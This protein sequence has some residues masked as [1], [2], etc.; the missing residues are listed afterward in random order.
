VERSRQ[1][2]TQDDPQSSRPAESALYALEEVTDHLRREV[3]LTL[4]GHGMTTSQY[5]VLRALRIHGT[6]GLTC[7]ELGDRLSGA[8]PDIT[9]LL[10]RLSRQQLI[11]RRRDPHDRRAVVTELT[12]E[13]AR[14]LAVV[15]P[16]LEARIAA[17]FQHMSAERL[18]LLLEL[19]EEVAEGD[20]RKPMQVHAMRAG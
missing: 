19:L 3:H 6:N 18:R 7:T 14:L 13:G 17:L 8:D 1:P 5:S 4:R 20:H 12:E 2:E 10:D 9:R 16:A 15:E 11:R